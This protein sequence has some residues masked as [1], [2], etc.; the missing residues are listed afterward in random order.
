M[1]WVGGEQRKERDGV[2]RVDKFTGLSVNQPEAEI[3]PL[4]FPFT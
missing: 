4:D 3:L 1:G 2:K